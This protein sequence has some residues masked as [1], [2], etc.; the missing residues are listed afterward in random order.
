MYAATS[1][2]LR[3][4]DDLEELETRAFD[5]DLQFVNNRKEKAYDNSE[6]EKRLEKL[7][8]TE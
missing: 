1:I 8:L 7:K 6:C 4:D 3:A 2:E 5:D